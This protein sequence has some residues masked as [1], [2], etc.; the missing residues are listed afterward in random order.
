VAA[1]GGRLHVAIRGLACRAHG[2]GGS[3]FSAFSAN[4]RIGAIRPDRQ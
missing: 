2:P 4:Y 3:P 1:S